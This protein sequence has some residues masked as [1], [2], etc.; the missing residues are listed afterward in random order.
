MCLKSLRRGHFPKL[1][2]L[3]IDKNPIQDVEILSEVHFSNINSLILEYRH[4]DN[5]IG[6]SLSFINKLN[7]PQQEHFCTF[8]LK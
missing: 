3:Q 7:S 4:K 1:N 8:E 2:C 5:V 6:E